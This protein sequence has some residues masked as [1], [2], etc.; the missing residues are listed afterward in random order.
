VNIKA[1][2]QLATSPELIHYAVRCVESQP[3]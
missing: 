2:L 1:K 3:A